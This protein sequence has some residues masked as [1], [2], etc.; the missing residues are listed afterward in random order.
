M[1]QALKD[2][3]ALTALFASGWEM[4]EGRD[5]LRKNF[6]FKSFRSAWGW[7]SEMALWAEQLDHHPDWSNTYNRVTVI[8]TTHDCDGLAE[9]DIKLAQQMDAAAS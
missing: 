6:K 1:T 5:A 8:L 2:R 7:M 4:V 3:S 9:V